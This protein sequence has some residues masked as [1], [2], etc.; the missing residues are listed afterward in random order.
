MR[1]RLS[2][3]D[4]RRSIV[5]R[6]PANTNLA[7]TLL[8][9]GAIVMCG[10][11]T[12]LTSHA[13]NDPTP[14][15]QLPSIRF[16]VDVGAAV[17]PLV[18]EAVDNQAMLAEDAADLAANG[19]GRQRNGVAVPLNYVAMTDP[20]TLN[21]IP[22]AGQLWTTAFTSVQAEGLRL[23]FT[24]ASMP[25][26]AELWVY[27][28]DYA[29][30]AQGPFEDQGPHRNGDIWSTVFAGDT[31]F[32]EYF[33]PDGATDSGNF[34]VAEL[35]HIYRPF[36]EPEEGSATEGPCHN[37]VMCYADWHPLHNATA[38][39]DFTDGGFGY[40]CSSTL[41]ATLTQDE[42]PYLLTANHCIGDQPTADTLVATWFY[43]KNACGGT[44]PSFNTLPK[45]DDATLLYTSGYIGVG[46]DS[47]LLMLLGAVPAG[48][49]W[50]G[51]TS[52]AIGTGIS[53]A[54]IHH[55]SGAYKRISFG[56]SAVH[57]FGDNFHYMGVVWNSGTIEPGSSGSGLYRV[58]DQAL[59]GV[60][61]HSAVPTDCSN[62]DGPSGYGRFSRT[63]PSIANLLNT[64][65]DDVY[66]LPANDTCAEARA[67]TQ[68]IYND[69]VVKSTDEDWY[70]V[71]LGPGGVVSVDL[72]FTNAWG[73]I[74]AEI[75]RDCNGTVVASGHGHSNHET[76]SY[77]NPA[78]G[79]TFY[80]RVYLATG[81]RNTYDMTLNVYCGTLAPPT[82]TQ[83]SDGA[84]C[85]HVEVTWIPS[86][87]A[88]GYNIWRV[89]SGS[90][91]DPLPIGYAT[92]SPYEDP[93]ATPGVVYDYSVESANPCGQGSMSGPDTGFA[94]C[95]LVGDVNCDGVVN[96]FD[97]SPFVLALADPAA[98]EATYPNCDILLADIN[99]DGQVN[100][101]D[102]TPFVTL[103]TGP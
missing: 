46:T 34:V 31:L 72:S 30:Y 70:S 94:Q 3:L 32:V 10:W 20:V 53:L 63:Y 29:D 22:G 55:P 54:G 100:N 47:T 95:G 83:A 37:D 45:S 77:S 90:G 97:I 87:G 5:I 19:L 74:D 27:E 76:V 64:G 86:A 65:S 16:G 71:F 101:F 91:D 79:R 60:C 51:W 35:L 42:T 98:Y 84:F 66:D 4:A 12:P 36:V 102:I 39:I 56:T 21:V 8:L 68:G 17:T 67:M 49:T 80:L 69:L 38:R 93:T 41:L 81:T 44:I 52:D 13:Q 14:P 24:G 1:K 11:L 25:P 48:V 85:D 78:G 59:V 103:L 75:Y 43:Q 2:L 15:P 61:S 50:A 18:L 6:Y 28:P 99:G 33:V 82:G 40:I 88:T 96:N 92:A 9:L 58:S 73:D 62:P 26:G 89:V 57:A 7:G 23:H